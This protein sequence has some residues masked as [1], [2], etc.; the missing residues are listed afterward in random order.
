MLLGCGRSAR[1]YVD[2]GNLLFDQGK[3]AEAE[4]NYRKAVQKDPKLGEAYHR[5]GLA[6]LKQGKATDAYQALS[7]AVQSMP[8]NQ[9]AKVDLATLAL[10]A[11]LQNPS[12]PK[13][14]YDL[15]VKLSAELLAKDPRSYLGLTVTAY[16]ALTEHRPG[17][18]VELFRRANE[19]KSGEQDAIL[20]YMQALVEQKRVGDAEKFGLESIA[21][22]RKAGRVYDALFRLYTTSGRPADAEK[23]L[24]RK[25]RDNPSESAYIVELAAYYA[26][27]RETQ[28]MDAALQPL[29]NN[30]SAFPDAQLDAGDFYLSIGEQSKALKQFQSGAAAH[31]KESSLYRNRIARCLVLQ[32]KRDEA[33]PVL[34]GLIKE[35]DGNTEAHMLRAVS[36]VENPLTGKPDAGITEFQV[37]VDQHPDDVSLRFLY[38]VALVERNKLTPAR[39][40]LLEVLKRSPGFLPARIALADLALRQGQ[41]DEAVRNAEAALELEPENFHARYVHGSALLG[42]G[43]L[44]RARADFTR[45]LVQAPKSVEVRLQMALVESRRKRF[46]EA[47][48]AYKKILNSSP[49]E[50]RALAGLVDNFAG[51][52]RLDKAIPFLEDE[53]RKSHGALAVRNLLAQSAAKAGRYDLAIEQYQ[54]MAAENPT[55]VDPLLRLAEVMNLKGDNSGAMSC[56]LKASI[57]DKKDARPRAMLAALLHQANR[58]QEAERQWREALAIQPGNPTLMNNLAYLLAETGD[59]LDEALKLASQ[60]STAE[61]AEASFADTLGWVCVKKGMNDEAIRMLRRLVQEHPDNSL[62]SYHFGMALYQKGEKSAAQLQLAHALN[63]Q[64]PPDLRDRINQA[65]IKLN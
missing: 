8:E 59:G 44:D 63:L 37:L 16:L 55:A 31:P 13:V 15:L 9:P 6:D 54:Q 42:Q 45:L 10:A 5:L 12:R 57:L 32:N 29:L 11:Y 23:I 3:F 14:L 46:D 49:H 38:S 40:Q 52:Q 51:Q 64:P 21:A 58:N 41:L 61:P 36:L 60:A 39:V 53:L 18:A 50:W 26:R 20:G 4:L 35:D 65:L 7:M 17:E 22:N 1:S 56:L 48:A 25:A 24:I 2:R 27:A 33:I 30:P 19:A 62:F 34:D 43:Q 47:E 28:E